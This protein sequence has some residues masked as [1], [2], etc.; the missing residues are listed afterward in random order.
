MSKC[1]LLKIGFNFPPSNLLIG[2]TF[3]R[4]EGNWEVYYVFLLSAR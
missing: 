2:L 3:K 4:A 1:A